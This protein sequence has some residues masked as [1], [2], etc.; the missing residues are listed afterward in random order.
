MGIIIIIA[1]A[2]I[3]ALGIFLG[4]IGG[5]SKTFT[6]A[7]AAMDSSSIKDQEQQTIEDTE[8][9]QK[10]LMDDMKQKREDAGQ[11]Y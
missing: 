10:K 9:K 3:W 2:G 7:P 4:L 6:H 1:V 5:L 8:E 11:N